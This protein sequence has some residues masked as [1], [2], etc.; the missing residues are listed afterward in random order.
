MSG[1]PRSKTA[2]EQQAIVWVNQWA[3]S[4]HEVTPPPVRANARL[5]VLL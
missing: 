5:R 4:R 1:G 2:A 3:F